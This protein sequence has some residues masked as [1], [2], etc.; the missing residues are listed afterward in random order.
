LTLDVLTLEEFRLHRPDLVSEIETSYESQLDRVRSE[1]DAMIAKEEARRRR[2]RI[3]QL[4]REYDLP[5][6]TPAG[7]TDS[8]LINPQFIET[9]MHS[10]DDESVRLL[11]E[12]RAALV[13]SACDWNEQRQIATRRPRSRDQLAL[14]ERNGGGHIQSAAQFA[15]A[16]RG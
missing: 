10:G 16:V 14:A 3:L 12:E 9:L 2:E 11:I 8:N 6:P 1:L 15:A 7:I 13:R 5:L 4:L